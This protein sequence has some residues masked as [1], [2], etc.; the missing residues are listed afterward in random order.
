MFYR[1]MMHG[2]NLVLGSILA[3]PW[4]QQLLVQ[5]ASA[6]LLAQ[7]QQ[8]AALLAQQQLQPAAL[9]ARPLAQGTP[10]QLQLQ[11]VQQQALLAQHQQALFAQRSGQQM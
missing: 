3:H 7:Q 9:T 4:A 11:V 6:A 1:C 10:S 2:F 5:A 8:Q